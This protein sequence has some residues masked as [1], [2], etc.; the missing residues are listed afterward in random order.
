M[1]VSPLTGK[2]RYNVRLEPSF[3]HALYGI[4]AVL[5]MT[6]AAWFVTDRM[7][8][9]ASEDIWQEAAPYLLMVHGGAAMASLMLLGALVPLHVQRAWQ[10]K[11]IWPPE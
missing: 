10:G 9:P 8:D 6:G 2:M 11:K 5:F 1:S 7:K 4:F 3:R